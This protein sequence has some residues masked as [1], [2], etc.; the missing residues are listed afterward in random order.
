MSAMTVEDLMIGYCDP[1]AHHY[2]EQWTQAIKVVHR[3]LEY[4]RPK[5]MHHP[6]MPLC[7][8]F[9]DA[10]KVKDFE[11]AAIIVMDDVGF[12]LGCGSSTEAIR[13]IA[14]RL[15][16]RLDGEDQAARDRGGLD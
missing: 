7:P 5:V 14:A 13:T 12:D 3:I 6:T 1:K 15:I 9:E 10:V 2:V 8:L 11:E 16:R 4:M